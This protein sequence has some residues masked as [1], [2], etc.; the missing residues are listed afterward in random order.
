MEREIS[1]FK[2]FVSLFKLIKLFQKIKPKV[3]H[4]NTPKGGLLSMIASWFTMVPVRIYCVHGLRYQGVNGIK[5][6]LL[7][8]MER[9]ACLCSTHV[10]TVSFGV[11]KILKEDKITSKMV[12]VIWNGSVNG[13]DS[14]RF[15]SEN[16]D[17][18][19]LKK[20]YNL[21]E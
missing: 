1:I 4:G 5:Y 11:R 2:D 3:V 21:D 12:E 18:T 14:E 9:L 6:F 20:K 8:N 13:I 17:V 16:M 7:K 15:S 10:F 19:V